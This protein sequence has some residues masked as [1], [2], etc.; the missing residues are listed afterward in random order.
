MGEMVERGTSPPAEIQ[1]NLA[2]SGSGM[3]FVYQAAFIAELMQRGWKFPNLVGT[4]G[5]SIVASVVA[6]G[7]GPGEIFQLLD[8]INEADFLDFR[9]LPF[10]LDRLP[11]AVHEALSGAPPIF[12]HLDVPVT[13]IAAK[14]VVLFAAMFYG[15]GAFAGDAMENYMEQLLAK[16]GIRTWRD[17]KEKVADGHA[18]NLGVIAY[19]S[20]NST[21]LTYPTQALVDVLKV[22]PEE[23]LDQPISLAVRQSASVFA[24]F[25]PVVLEVKDGHLRRVRYQP[26][27]R[28]A[29]RQVAVSSRRLAVNVWQWLDE[30]PAASPNGNEPVQWVITDGGPAQ[31]LGY[32]QAKDMDPTLPTIGIDMSSPRPLKKFSL[33]GL[34]SFLKLGL[35][36]GIESNGAAERGLLATS[37]I[38]E[39][40]NFPHLKGDQMTPLT[41]EEKAAM[42]A[43]AV[44]EADDFDNWFRGHVEPYM[45][46][47]PPFADFK[48]W[49]CANVPQE[50][51]NLAPFLGEFWKQ[52]NG[53]RSVRSLV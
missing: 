33:G 10:N 16:K 52:M 49:F 36:I 35:N 4:S 17:L 5:G 7:Y 38:R 1:A 51:A 53:D 45:L 3:H 24:A 40:I 23:A 47:K 14:A 41:A 43:V 13:T 46:R 48:Q 22:M 18:A 6:A 25:E 28:S 9:K 30:K 31:N 39:F 50:Y 15:Q 34:I 2:A 29:L 26:T 27:L 21:Q 11:G 8:D 19:A 37:G 20:N 32:Y 12:R 42:I 44:K